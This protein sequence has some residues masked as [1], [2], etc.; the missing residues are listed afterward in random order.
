[1]PIT[2]H[3]WLIQVGLTNQINI[4]LLT[5]IISK[6]RARSSTT[7]NG[8]CNDSVEYNATVL[9]NLIELEAMTGEDG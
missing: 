7:H 2:F 6:P 5:A 9:N 1:M 4:I 3:G 8:R